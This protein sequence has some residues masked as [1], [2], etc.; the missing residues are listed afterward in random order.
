MRL[1]CAGNALYDIIS[2]VDT[3]FPSSVGLH[4]GLTVHMSRTELEPLLSALPG[5]ACGA[6]GGAANT[7]RVFSSLGFQA[8][9]AGR[10]GDDE[11]G[12]RYESDLAGSGVSCHLERGAGSTGLFCVMLEPDGKRTVAV[13]PGAASLLAPDAIPDSFFSPDSTLYVDGFLADRPETVEA[14]VA[15]ATKAGM[16]MALDIGG[17]R[18]AARNRG[19]FMRLI[20]ERCLWTFMNEDEY[21]ALSGEGVDESLIAFSASVPGTLVVKRAEVGA[22]TVSDG[23]IIESAV[24]S[25]QARDTTGAGDSFAAGFLAAALSKAPL[26]RCLRLGNRI[27]E[28]ALAVPGVAV[29]AVRL[30]KAAAAVL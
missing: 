27:A 28:Q 21:R 30:R 2:F 14:I 29:D 22:V 16:A 12:G 7:A 24:R 19:F 4:G 10:I 3:D 15:R 23:D 26:A 20:R 17:S 6:G 11:Y 13:S 8:S 9:F 25:I 5:S 18:I 1:S